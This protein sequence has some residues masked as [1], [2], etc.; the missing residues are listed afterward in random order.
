MWRHEVLHSVVNHRRI[1][2]KD[3][4]ARSIP[5]EGSSRKHRCGRVRRLFGGVH[6]DL[7]RVTTRA[8]HYRVTRRE[9]PTQTLSLYMSETDKS[10]SG[11]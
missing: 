10:Y 11:A 7:D 5:V 3:G 1:D 2:G 4:V 6:Q 8:G 9:P